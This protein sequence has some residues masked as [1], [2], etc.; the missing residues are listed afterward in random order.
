MT[1]IAELLRQRALASPD[2]VGVCYLDQQLTWLQFY[3]QA[4]ALSE[5]LAA[6]GIGR[7]DPVGVHLPHSL[8]QAV[9]IFA[10]AMRDAIFTVISPLLVPEQVQHQVNDAAAKAVIAAPELL[11]PMAE[12]YAARRMHVETLAATGLASGAVTTP[13]D[14]ATPVATN[15][16][17]DIANYIYT[18]GS[19]GLPKGI[20]VPQ[21]TLL[22]GARIVS[23]YLRLTPQDTILS[24]L[25]YSFD[26]GLNQLL[27]AIHTGARIVIHQFIFPKDLLD[28]LEAQRITGLAAVPP[29]WPKL[30]KP[31]L[32]KERQFE[33]LRYITSGG[34]FHPPQLLE[35]IAAFFPHTDIIVQYGLTEAFRSTFLPFAEMRRRP[36]SIGRAVPEVEI[37][38]LNERGEQ[39]APGEK[40]ELVHRGAFVTYGYLNNPELT[41]QKFVP[42][43]RGTPACLPEL[44][45]RSGD[46]VSL[47]ADG[48]LYFHGRM[49]QQIK[50]SGYRISPDEVAQAVLSTPGISLTAVWGLPDEEL[51]EAIHVAYETASGEALD[52]NE[53]RRHSREHLA[54]YAVPHH[55]HFYEKLPVNPNGKLDFGALKRHARERGNVPSGTA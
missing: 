46:S 50:S 24:I 28:I 9:A 1:N 19:T 48:F 47:D 45:V 55:Y 12:F 53:I 21:R 40:G 17:A 5:R 52:S 23:G 33:H 25:P 34:G 37:L 14:P 38:V 18:S 11:A 26:Y 32:K 20:V 2:A 7:G 10:I 36:G 27:G 42:M 3:R 30:L 49:D 29:V 35:N 43:H 54:P 51:G 6:A 16:P 41:A 13:A 8:G 39:C 22:D 31:A 15:I 44:A 4:H